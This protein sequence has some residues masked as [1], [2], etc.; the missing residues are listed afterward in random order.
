M[1]FSDP[2]EYLSRE[3]E[4]FARLLPYSTMCVC[5][6][7]RREQ[8]N[9]ERCLQ[10][11]VKT[12]I[13]CTTVLCKKHTNQKIF[14]IPHSYFTRISQ[15]DIKLNACERRRRV[16]ENFIWMFCTLTNSVQKHIVFAQFSQ[17]QRNTRS[18]LNPPESLSQKYV[19]LRA[20][21]QPNIKLTCDR[22]RRERENFGVY[23]WENMKHYP[24]WE[25][26]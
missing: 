5:E 25:V 20:L 6:C 19:F 13:F 21:S 2:Q 4:F 8:E 3:R 11:S 14:K 18:F 12:Y 22:R 9:F 15:Y 10:N 17:T 26:V 24:Y 7:G 16:R 1:V 23:E